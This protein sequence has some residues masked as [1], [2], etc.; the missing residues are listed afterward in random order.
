VLS[1]VHALGPL[2]SLD[3][4]ER[5]CQEVKRLIVATQLRQ[6]LSAPASQKGKAD[7]TTD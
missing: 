1:E 7:A 5:L 4:R 2:W 3:L 6:R